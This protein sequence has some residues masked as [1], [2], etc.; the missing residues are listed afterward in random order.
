MPELP[1]VFGLLLR[2]NLALTLPAIALPL[3]THISYSSY[4]KSIVIENAVIQ[5]FQAQM[6]NG[7]NGL[8]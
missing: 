8:F 5:K 3:L 6:K 2:S 1:T 7:E 4:A